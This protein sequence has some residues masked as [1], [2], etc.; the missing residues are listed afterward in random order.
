MASCFY[1]QLATNKYDKRYRNK[2]LEQQGHV[3]THHSPY[4][5]SD[6]FGQRP[7][8]RALAGIDRSRKSLKYIRTLTFWT[9]FPKETEWGLGRA[10]C[11]AGDFFWVSAKELP[12]FESARERVKR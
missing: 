11:V 2:F 4:Q 1:K 8:P 9:I 7:I 3:M 5:S 10:A 6:L 12:G